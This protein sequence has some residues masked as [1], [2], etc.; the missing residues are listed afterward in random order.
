MKEK[1]KTDGSYLQ[2]LQSN[3]EECRQRF[4]SI[5]HLLSTS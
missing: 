4:T 2:G 3:S 1:M 5:Q